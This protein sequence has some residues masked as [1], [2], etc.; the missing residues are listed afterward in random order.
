MNGLHG[1]IRPTV[2]G[3]TLAA[4]RR[5]LTDPD[6]AV[7]RP[8]PDRAAQL[9]ELLNAPPRLAA[10]LR[11]V[12]DVAW[13]LTDELS[14][15]WPEL[16]F[17]R[18]TVLF[19]AAIHDIGKVVHPAELS[20]P[21]SAHERAGFELLRAHGVPANEARFAWTHAA[22]TSAGITTE[23][24]LVSV[25]DKI[26][27]G[28]RVPDLETLVVNRLTTAA[29]LDRWQAF[30]ALDDIVGKIAEDADVR[31]A[32]QARYPVAIQRES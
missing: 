19:G 15:R 4:L 8:L 6:D 1:G 10:H 3:V 13:Q 23:D 31:L 22:W 2:A 12:H 27:K 9:L 5:A 14:R 16:R 17:D 11:A 30:I 21:G 32:F 25:A 18:P 24:L 7:A 20:G 28:K 26:W 29:G